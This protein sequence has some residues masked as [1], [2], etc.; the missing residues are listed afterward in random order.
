VAAGAAREDAG[1]QVFRDVIMGSVV[2]AVQFG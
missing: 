2:S 1:K